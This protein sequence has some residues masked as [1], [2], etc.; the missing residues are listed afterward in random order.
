MSPAD[1]EVVWP[2]LQ[3][4]LSS[5][6]LMLAPEK[7]K[8]YMPGATK[9]NPKITRLLEQRFDGLPLLGTALNGDLESFLGPFSLG[10]QPAKE[11]PERAIKLLAQIKAM[12]HE[13]LE[14]SMLQAGWCLVSSCAA[15]NLDFDTRVHTPGDISPLTTVLSIATTDTVTHLLGLAGALTQHTKDQLILGIN[16]GGFGLPNFTAAA[17]AARLA[18]CIQVRPAVSARLQ[19]VG[20]SRFA[21]PVTLLAKPKT[22]SGA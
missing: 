17:P 9:A 7:C 18:A 11:R 12:T 8:A 4:C 15:H 3:S 16:E 19:S 21:C 13:V 6:G 10:V 22:P 1:L 5:A 2:L 20:W 14:S